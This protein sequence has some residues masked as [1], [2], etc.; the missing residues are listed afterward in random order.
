[1]LFSDANKDFKIATHGI[2]E[3]LRLD[4][5]ESRHESSSANV[6]IPTAMNC[7]R[8]C[9]LLPLFPLNFADYGAMGKS[10]RT[11]LVCR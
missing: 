4:C 1:M 2:D 10:P 6:P 3:L 7:Y 5:G 11:G 9:L 8:T